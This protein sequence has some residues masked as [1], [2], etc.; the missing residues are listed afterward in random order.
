MSNIPTADDLALTSHV[1]QPTSA[2]L[3]SDVATESKPRERDSWM[4]DPGTVDSA[5]RPAA[6]VRDIP[7]SAGI[8]TSRRARHDDTADDFLSAPTATSTDDD[9]FSAMGT[10]HKRKDP[11]ADKPD[12]SKLQIHWNELNK[13]LLMGKGLDDNEVKEKKVVHGGPGYQWRMMKL[14]RLYEQAEEQ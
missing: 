13:Q 14:R 9:L 10:E 4:L 12:V 1:S 2:K 3:P 6:A 7:R 8:S 11:N 5:S